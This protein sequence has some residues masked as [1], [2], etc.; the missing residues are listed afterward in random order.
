VLEVGPGLGSLTRYLAAA[1]RNVVAVELDVDLIPPLTSLLATYKN[2]HIIQGDIL[3]MDPAHLMQRDGYLAVSN[4]PYYI[5]SAF[6]RHLLE[7]Q[8]SPKRVIITI[9]QEVAERIIA[10]PG[11]MSL[12]ALSVQ[13][14]GSPRIVARI[15]AG[16]FYPVPKVD[17]AT[18][19]I[20]QYPNPQIPSVLL[21]SFFQLAR[22]GFSQKRKTLRN[23]LSGGMGWT[24]HETEALLESASIDPMRRAET[25]SIN[26]WRKLTEIY[27]SKLTPGPD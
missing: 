23:A 14:F 15:P 17:S 13:V 10:D 16:S 26:E 1:A 4:V 9:Q 20:D 22:A 5:T 12:L 3:A 19:R 8:V 21:P 11:K 27:Y 2:I 6:I 18:L 25:L 24:R 7:V